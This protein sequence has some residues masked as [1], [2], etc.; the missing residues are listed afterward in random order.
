[1]KSHQSFLQNDTLKI[2]NK[3]QKRNNYDETSSKE[4]DDYLEVADEVASDLEL[5][6]EENRV[7]MEE[8]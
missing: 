3:N 6:N 2:I 1:M 8:S 5:L 7:F 4:F